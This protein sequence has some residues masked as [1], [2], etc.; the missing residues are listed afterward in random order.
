LTDVDLQALEILIMAEP[1]GA[2]VIP[3]TGGLRK[4]RFGRADQGARGAYRVCYVYFEEV[5]I[6]H[7]LV[8]FAKNEKDDLSHAERKACRMLIEDIEKS[9]YQ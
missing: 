9:L 7:L 1:K 6:V 4:L 5:R 2:P 8:I 3:Q